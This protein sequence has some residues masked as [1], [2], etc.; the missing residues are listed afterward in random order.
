MGLTETTIKVNEKNE[1]NKMKIFQFSFYTCVPQTIVKSKLGR[2]PLSPEFRREKDNLN[3]MWSLR[4]TQGD[5]EA[6]QQHFEVPN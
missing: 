3:C 1:K 5:L 4:S 6:N 2:R